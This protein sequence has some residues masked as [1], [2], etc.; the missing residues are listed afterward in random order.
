G[1]SLVTWA[2]KEGKVQGPHFVEKAISEWNVDPAP[3]ITLQPYRTA[4]ESL[5][6]QFDRSGAKVITVLQENARG[7]DPRRRLLAARG[8]AAINAIG[9]LV[10]LL[11][12]EGKDRTDVRRAAIL[13]L[14]QTL[15]RGP[16]QGNLLYD[17]K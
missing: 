8:L 13:S 16:E 10:D 9:P 15:S 5:A 14:R 7:D 3:S 17:R 2:N 11:G 12:D 1:R 4:L 6:K